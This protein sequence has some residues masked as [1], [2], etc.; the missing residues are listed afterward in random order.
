MD[1][2]LPA[3]PEPTDEYRVV[4]GFISSGLRRIEF[5]S[6]GL[7]VMLDFQSMQA[8]GEALQL[9]LAAGD[10]RQMLGALQHVVAKLQAEIAALPPPGP[11][12]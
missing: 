2:P 4:A 6:H 10:A 1:T 3:V 7:G 9:C 5:D 11:T 12:Q 8:P